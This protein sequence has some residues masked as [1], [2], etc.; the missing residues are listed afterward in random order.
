MEVGMGADPPNLR[1]AAGQAKFV[2][3]RWSVVLAAGEVAGHEAEDALA[4][5]CTTYWYPLY[6]YIRRRVSNVH[7]AQDLTQA[8]FCHL[9]EKHVI[10]RADRNRG[11][12]RTFLLA[13]LTNFLNNEWHKARALKRG[14]GN[15]ELPLDFDSGDSRYQAEPSHELT[16]EKLYER[17]WVMALLEQVLG[18]LRRELADAGHAE[19][20]EPFK[21]TLTGEASAAEYERAAATLGITP[22]AAKQAAYRLRKRY[23]QLFREEVAQTVGDEADVDDEIRRLM[24]ALGG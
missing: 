15:I 19:H 11:R 7:E 12:F 13:A 22:A 16:P 4:Q 18:R 1:A 8:F 24:A 2:T 3:T 17:R 6:A 10:A 5:L 23:R 20:F 14:Q 9:L 21:G